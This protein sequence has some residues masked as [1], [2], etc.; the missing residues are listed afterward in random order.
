MS[1]EYVSIGYPGVGVDAAAAAVVVVAVGYAA[2]FIPG[3]PNDSGLSTC[4]HLL[5]L[6]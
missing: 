1:F 5:S 6:K 4:R 3:P 2:A